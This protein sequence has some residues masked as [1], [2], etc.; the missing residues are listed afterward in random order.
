MP[1]RNSLPRLLFRWLPIVAHV[2]GR[3]KFPLS[4]CR[5]CRMWAEM[6]AAALEMVDDVAC[7]WPCLGPSILAMEAILTK[8]KPNRIT[9]GTYEVVI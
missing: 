4:S 2:G 9:I 5:R 1:V 3:L 8:L 7:T 6:A